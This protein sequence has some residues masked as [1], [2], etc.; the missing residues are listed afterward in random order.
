[1]LSCLVYTISKFEVL[2][3]NFEVAIFETWMMLNELRRTIFHGSMRRRKL[4]IELL[5]TE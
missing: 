4:A 3:L 5:L 2:E 1:M